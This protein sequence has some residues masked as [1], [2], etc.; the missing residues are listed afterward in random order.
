[1]DRRS[2]PEA[3]N[4]SMELLRS[5]EGLSSQLKQMKKDKLVLRLKAFG[6]LRHL[7]VDHFGSHTVAG[8]PNLVLSQAMSAAAN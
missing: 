4:A 1:V 7:L 3:L 8:R 6:L 2:R 5:S